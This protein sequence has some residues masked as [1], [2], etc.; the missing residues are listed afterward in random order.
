MEVLVQ[1]AHIY[2]SFIATRNTLTVVPVHTVYNARWDG[3]LLETWHSYL[4]HHHAISTSQ[5][6][7]AARLERVTTTLRIPKLQRRQLGQVYSSL[8]PPSPTSN[9]HVTLTPPAF[10]LKHICS[11][12]QRLQRR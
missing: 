1:C 3:D 7:L 8:L 9:K 12:K 2:T 6:H 11:H 5:S 4:S 10:A